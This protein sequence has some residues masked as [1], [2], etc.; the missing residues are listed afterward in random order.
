M[1]LEIEIGLERARRTGGPFV[2]VPADAPPEMVAALS[3][4]ARETG[5]ETLKMAGESPAMQAARAAAARDLPA[6][7]KGD[8]VSFLAN[9]DS[10]ASGKARVE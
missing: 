2:F 3:A 4:F 7:A 9:L 1:N 5:R 8:N 10:I 6:V